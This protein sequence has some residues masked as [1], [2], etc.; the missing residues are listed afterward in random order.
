VTRYKGRHRR[1]TATDRVVESVVDNSGRIVAA[2]VT[3]GVLAAIPATAHADSGVDPD[4]YRAAIIQ[5]ESQN[6]NVENPES[7]ASGYYQFLDGTWA[8]FGGKEFAPR[9]IQATR[10]EQ[11]IVFDRAIAR[12][13]TRDWEADPRSERCWRPK[14]GNASAPAP[15]EKKADTPKRSNGKVAEQSDRGKRRA[16]TDIPDGYVVKRGDT[17]NKIRARFDVDESVREIAK[18]NGIKNPNR[19]YVGQKLN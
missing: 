13:G 5:C 19:I 1:L 10:A 8:A 17:L 15:A 3:T 7:S 6:R 18:A 11:D 14:V 12:N 2:T 16:G 9:A 4:K